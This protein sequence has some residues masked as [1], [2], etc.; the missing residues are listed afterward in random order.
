[1]QSQATSTIL[2][3]RP[4]QF[5]YNEETAESNTFQDE[6]TADLAL[7]T[8][9]TKAL[10]EFDEM[11]DR[12][13][14][15][16]VNVIVYNDTAETY[17]PDSIFPNNWV[18]FHASGKVVLYPMQAENRRIERRMDIIDD[19]RK[20][21]S[22]EVIFDFSHYEKEGLF[23]EGTGSLILDR[24]HRVAYACLSTRTDLVVL[25]AWKKQMN[26]YETVVFKAFGKDGLPIYHTNVM[27]CM[28]NTFVVICL[29]AVTDLDERL[30]LK[31]KLETTNKNIIEISM[32]QMASFAGN[33]LLVQKE[34]GGHL[35]VMSQSAY[36]SLTRAQILELEEYAELIS[37]DLSMIETCGGGSARCM[38]AE[39]HLPKK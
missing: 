38:M 14:L 19:L 28:G 33:M 32:E 25:N 17:T 7:K 3:I 27:M 10:K 1:M 22:V 37:F 9:Q 34:S 16:G 15:A 4:V 5:S 21:F 18:S 35:L 12:L 8:T 13:R 11:V 6:S 30:A 23:L 20:S 39:V 24:M 2:M 36:G 31:A 26:G 29:E